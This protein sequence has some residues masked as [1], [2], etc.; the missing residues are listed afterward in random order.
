MLIRV[1][2]GVSI[3]V[4][5]ALVA[6]C[7]VERAAR[8]SEPTPP[9]TAVTTTTTAV[10]PS[11]PEPPVDGDTDPS[12]AAEPLST[13]FHW[14]ATPVPASVRARMDGV[15]MRPGCPV[16]Y[17]QLSYVQ[18]SH[19][20]FQG[21]VAS[22]EL[23]VAAIEAEP[24]SSVFRE[25]FD[26]KFQIRRMS[27]VDDFGL[28]PDPADGADDFASIEADNTSAF[29]CRLRTGSDEVFSDHSFGT[30]IDLNPLE[31]P[32]VGSS[33]TTP[34]PASRPYLDRSVVAPGVIGA[35]SVVTE[36]FERIGWSWGGDWSAPID[37]QHFS[38]SGR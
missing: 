34:H 31:N 16:T 8:E 13:E 20:D 2:S 33:G 32:Y 23:V 38:R 19:W 4:V 26:A 9:S 35:D 11:A 17:E 12:T 28:S 7:S 24:L 5:A 14:A 29:N 22:G 25:L 37:Y 21:R 18:V 27:L 15:S 36:A 6:G 10:E 3:A 30:A 1:S